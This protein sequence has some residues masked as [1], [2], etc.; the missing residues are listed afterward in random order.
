MHAN[1]AVDVTLVNNPANMANQI[2]C[3]LCKGRGGHSEQQFSNMVS[4]SPDASA[5]GTL[6]NQPANATSADNKKNCKAQTFGCGCA[7]GFFRTTSIENQVFQSG[8][9]FL[10]N[11]K[12]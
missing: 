8:P 1:A 5:C 6:H 9:A 3:L 12:T 11:A 4:T 2:F 10:P 7:K